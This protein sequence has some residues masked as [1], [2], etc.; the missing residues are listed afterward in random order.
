L[1]EYLDKFCIIYLDDIIIYSR[2]REEYIGHVRKILAAL[3]SRNL[4]CKL[5]KCEFGVSETVFLGF[6]ISSQG[7]RLDPEKLKAVKDWLVPT[8]VKGVRGFLGFANFI[9]KFIKGYSEIA[10]LLTAL[11]RKDQGFK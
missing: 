2:T 9:R 10:E 4:R 5:S 1:S 11:I 3:Q 6:V 7:L 8:T